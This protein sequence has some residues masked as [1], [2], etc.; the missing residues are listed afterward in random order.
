MGLNL[1][2]F[3]KNNEKILNETTNTLNYKKI[4]ENKINIYTDGSCI[5]NGNKNSNGGIGIW[6]KKLDKRNYS[7]KILNTTNNETELMAI[8]KAIKIIEN[9]INNFIRRHIQ[10]FI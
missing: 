3:I 4:V 5:N 8:I 6:F 9:M 2:L 7:E 1:L 10:H